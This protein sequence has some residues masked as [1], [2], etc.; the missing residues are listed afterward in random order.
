MRLWHEALIQK[1]PRQQL[2]GQHRECAALRGNG[3]G[4]KHATVNYVFQHSPYKLFQFHELVMDEMER[5]GYHPDSH[6]R[7]PEYRGKTCPP[8]AEL[9]PCP[10]THPIYPEHDQRYLQECQQL[11]AER[12]KKE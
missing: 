12:T 1:L 11:L 3:W 9:A 4:R 10:R 5:R 8:Y 6:W 2:L 7:Q